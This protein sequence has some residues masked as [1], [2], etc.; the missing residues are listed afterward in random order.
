MDTSEIN[1]THIFT[2]IYLKC[3]ICMENYVIIFNVFSMEKMSIM[4]GFK[5]ICVYINITVII[6]VYEHKYFLFFISKSLSVTR[7]LFIVADAVVMISN[8]FSIECLL[9]YIVIKKLI[10]N[11]Y[12]HVSM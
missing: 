10:R 9:L 1:F 12:I 7:I 11:R 5:K 3:I 2:R 4:G 6:I 8:M